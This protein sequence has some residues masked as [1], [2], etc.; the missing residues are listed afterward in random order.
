[1]RRLILTACVL[2]GLVGI[3]FIPF[4]DPLPKLQDVSL[5]EQLF[6]FLHKA[7]GNAHGQVDLF[8]LYTGSTPAK[9]CLQPDYS[10]DEQFKQISPDLSLYQGILKRPYRLWI[11]PQ[12]GTPRWANS[13]YP[14]RIVF[15]KDAPL[16][17]EG[18]KLA[19]SVMLTREGAHSHFT[20]H[21][22][23]QK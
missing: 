2:I 14:A 19:L 21:L 20:I 16:C 17:V 22:E 7:T 11:I 15:T 4:P 1:M 12:D 9:A 18:T 8:P 3:F 6:V 13:V 23:A 10:S 5:Q